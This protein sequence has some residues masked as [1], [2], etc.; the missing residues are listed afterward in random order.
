MLLY[1]F[2]STDLY[3]HSGRQQA[4][5]FCQKFFYPELLREDIIIPEEWSGEENIMTNSDRVAGMMRQL[6]NPKKF[7]KY[8]KVTPPF[9]FRGVNSQTFNKFIKNSEFVP[10]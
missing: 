6:R 10:F 8:R 9:P 7:K 4:C 2:Y 1:Q 5:L 3:L